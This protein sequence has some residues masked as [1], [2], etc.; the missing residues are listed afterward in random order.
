MVAA[1]LL[2]LTALG[3]LYECDNVPEKAMPSV[4]V[5]DTY[6]SRGTSIPYSTAHNAPNIT[7]S[8]PGA[9]PKSSYAVAM[10]DPD[11]PSPTQLTFR[12]IRHWLVVN[13]R[14]A[15]LATGAVEASG[16]TLTEFV[17]PSKFM[18]AVKGNGAHRY[19]QLVYAQKAARRAFAPLPR[20][21]AQWNVTAWAASE[22]LTLAACNYFETK[23][24]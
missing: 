18:G 22:D 24:A 16:T 12:E 11:A 4:K 1:L 21:I 8:W 9:D 5:G 19:V 10:I 23:I 6:A 15:D 17:N 2:S 20:S 13:V 14:G 7:I 3:S